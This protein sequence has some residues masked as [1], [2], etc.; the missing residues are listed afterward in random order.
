MNILRTIGTVGAATV[1]LSLPALAQGPGGILP[2]PQDTPNRQGTRGANFLH[3]PIGA[4]GGAMAGAIGSTVAGPTGWFW[5]PAGAA[6]SEAF[7]I[8]AGRQQLYD[9]L[10]V[11]QTYVGA[12]IPLLGGVVGMHFN[13]LG[14]G[15]IRRTTE[16]N[17]FG[18]RL[19]GN[20]FEWTSTVVGLGYARRLTDRLQVGGQVKYITEGIPDASTHWTAFDVGTQFNTGL[21]GLVLGG[22]IQNVG[23]TSRA[24]GALIQRVISTNDGSQIS[25]ARRVQYFTNNTELPIEFRLSIG[26]DLYGGANSLFGG[27]D[28]PSTL[29]AEISVTDATDYSTQYAIGAEY[30]YKNMLFVRGGKRMYNDDRD[31]GDV[32]QVGLTGGFGLRLP[33]LGR[34]IRF[35][36][37]YEAAG[38]LQNIQVFSFEVGK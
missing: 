5:N 3:I 21:Y 26:S 20:A 12:S 18:E 38:A 11:T 22:A 35:D 10:D 2:T 6:T 17:P 7:S 9:D 34:N 29:A 31:R 16:L 32:G 13:T 36:Y 19:G 15:P 28:G 23:G 8:A 4:R 14:S 24:N 33:V 25:E 1:L 30:G 37:S 27:A